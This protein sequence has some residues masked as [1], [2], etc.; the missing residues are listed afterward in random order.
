MKQLFRSLLSC[1]LVALGVGRA[2]GQ[3]GEADYALFRGFFHHTDGEYCEH[4]PP[5]VGFVAYLNGDDGAILT[6]KAPRWAPGADPNIPGTGIFSIEL[7]NFQDPEVAEGD[8]FFIRLTCMVSQSQMVYGDSIVSFPLLSV[9][10][11]HYLSEAEIPAAPD[12]V[13]VAPAD[14]VWTVTWDAEPSL[15]YSVYRRNVLDLLPTGAARYQYKKLAEELATDTFADSSVGSGGLYGYIVFAKNADGIYSLYSEEARSDSTGLPIEGLTAI[16]RNTT[17]ELH[18]SALDTSAFELAGYNVY[19]SIDGE[20]WELAAYTDPDT[21]H[22]DSR[23]LPGETYYYK[24]TARTTFGNEVGQSQIVATET[25]ATPELYATYA[26]LDVLVVIY[27]WTTSGTIPPEAVDKIKFMV[28]KSRGFSWINSGLKLNLDIDYLVMEEYYDNDSMGAIENQLHAKGVMD[29]QYDAVFRIARDPGGFWSWG[30]RENWMGPATGFSYS[31]WPVGAGVRYPDSEPGINHGLTWIFTHEFQHAL[32]AI[33]YYN[34]HPEMYH[35][36][37]PVQFP[38]PAGEHYDFQA[39]ILRVFSAYEDL[40]PSWGRLLEA[41][42]T[43]GDGFV[44]EDE[45]VPFDEVDIGSSIKSPDTDGDGLSDYEEAIAGHF[46]GSNPQEEDTDGDEVVDGED[47]YPLYNMRPEISTFKPIIDGVIEEEWEVLV[48]SVVFSS[49]GFRPKFYAA[50]DADSLYVAFYTPILG[51]PHLFIDAVTDGW[52][53]SSDNYEL[54]I[55]PFSGLFIT[56][57]IYDSSDEAKACSEDAGRGPYG[58][59]DDESLYLQCF[60]Q[61]LINPANFNLKATNE[62]NEY[63]VE[64]AIPKNGATHLN[65]LAG[66]SIAFR[67]D[68]E[69]VNNSYSRWA[70]TFDEYS[71]VKTWLTTPVSITGESD[72]PRTFALHQNYPNPFNPVTSI[73]YSLPVATEVRLT[74]YNLLGRE[75][76][77]LVEGFQ[78]PGEYSVN[79]DASTAASGVYFVRLMSDDYIATRKMVVLK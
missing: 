26:T 61:R 78:R 21:L 67:M 15:T 9:P 45:R 27:L 40:T 44:D 36:D 70:A 65:L 50:W 60:G 22:T 51:L 25:D 55:N 12:N 5:E 34:G 66:D 79:W 46:W 77:T 56:A 72:L 43:D 19:Q 14:S 28:E 11:H 75:V 4:T 30:V 42:D 74:V 52:W 54:Y 53:Y 23:L 31:Q 35:G 32:D 59:W 17:A 37:V 24:V 39:G 29:G 20:N 47:I 18:W 16:P 10:Y 73:A 8:S 13:S 2:F 64:L 1:I 49:I 48:D 71:F 68:Y 62:G 63:Q 41:E 33:Y 69:K 7:G 76:T 6:N 3:P 58:L 57:H 38:Y